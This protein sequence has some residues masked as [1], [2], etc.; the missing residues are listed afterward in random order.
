ARRSRTGEE[1][2]DASWTSQEPAVRGE[3][4]HYEI[5]FGMKTQNKRPAGEAGLLSPYAVASGR[6]S[7]LQRSEPSLRDPSPRQRRHSGAFS[8]SPPFMRLKTR[9]SYHRTWSEAVS[10][11]RGN[12]SP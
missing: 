2:G 7:P 10:P 8:R 1:G 3:G 6:D 12:A 4:Y 9:S 5:S 11:G